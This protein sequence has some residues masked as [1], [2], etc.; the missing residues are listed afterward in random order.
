MFCILRAG[1]YSSVPLQEIVQDLNK[2]PVYYQRVINNRLHHAKDSHSSEKSESQRIIHYPPPLTLVGDTW[3]SDIKKSA[4]KY[5][6][7]IFSC[8]YFYFS[9][10]SSCASSASFC[11]FSSASLCSFSCSLSLSF[12]F[13][14]SS[15][16]TNCKIS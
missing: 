16:C 12:I 4:F 7:L 6:M 1:G 2:Q 14:S 11:A 5:R 10:Y 3:D 8:I 9:A 15:F 13:N